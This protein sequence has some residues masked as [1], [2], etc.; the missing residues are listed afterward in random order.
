VPSLRLNIVA[1]YAGQLVS[2]LVGFAVVPIYLR[3]VGAEGY[4]VIG[5]LVSIQTVLAVLDLGLSTTANREIGRDGGDRDTSP[6]LVRTLEWVYFSTGLLIFAGVAGASNYLAHDWVQSR[7]I[8]P[9][10][11]RQCVLIAGAIIGLRWPVALYGGVLRGMEKQVQ[12]NLLGAGFT[13]LRAF[14]AVGCLAFWAPTV[15]VYFWSQLFAGAAELAAH[16]FVCTKYLRRPDRSASF[17][18]EILRRVWGFSWRV[19]GISLCAVLIKQ[20]DRVAISKLLTLT[21]LGYYT[22][23]TVIGFGLSRAYG[24]VQAAVFPRF[25]RLIALGDT[26]A[27]STVFHQSARLVSFITTP[28]AAAC[29]FFARDILFFWTRD[30]AVADHAALPLQIYAVAMWFNSMMGLP[31]MLQ[32]AA[33]LTWLPLRTNIIGAV[34]LGPLVIVFVRYFGLAGGSL[35]WLIFN[36][37]YFLIV[38]QILFR[39]VLRGEKREWYFYDSLGFVSC[40]LCVFGAWRLFQVE[41]F[42]GLSFILVSLA[43]G[44]SYCVAVTILYPSLRLK[45]YE[46][47][48]RFSSRLKTI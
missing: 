45:L 15:E 33:G 16:W 9:E 1:N 2:T 13:L 23:A 28:L 30:A 12:L 44:A 6:D 43:A 7:T 3:Y 38:P 20:I 17:S 18:W 31:Y 29:V 47:F 5:F 21:E 37:G 25:N 48:N 41:F 11:I 34:A 14:V 24:P 35:A 27:L 4:G 42:P 39:H 10:T 19:A 32:L 46:G 26:A 22:T 36:I 40:G 8:P